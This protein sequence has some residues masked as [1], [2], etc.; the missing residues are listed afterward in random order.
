MQSD[1]E[2]RKKG[3]TE[4]A[5]K[6]ETTETPESRSIF[7]EEEVRDT[8]KGFLLA[9]LRGEV[10]I[11]F[12][13]AP[14][15]QNTCAKRGKPIDYD[16]AVQSEVAVKNE[17]TKLISI[18]SGAKQSTAEEQQGAI[19]ALFEDILTYRSSSR[20]EG[21]FFEYSLEKK[22]ERLEQGLRVTNDLV[23]QLV[24]LHRQELGI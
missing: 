19:T 12:P 21:N 9:W 10:K 17:F 1:E 6:K 8:I 18:C 23:E 11:K 15:F 13:L 2:S 16:E 14:E 3:Q 4:K 7:S 22:L 24:A 5:D 20:I